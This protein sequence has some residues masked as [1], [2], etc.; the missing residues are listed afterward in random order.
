MGE[1]SGLV[2]LPDQLVG[3]VIDIGG[4]LATVGDGENITIRIIALSCVSITV[5]GR[6]TPPTVSSLKGRKLSLKKHCSQNVHTA[7][8]QSQ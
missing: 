7:I 8:M 1:V 3:G 2:V 6:L 5:E 4:S